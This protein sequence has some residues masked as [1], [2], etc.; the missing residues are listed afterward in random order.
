MDS[1]DLDRLL[2]FLWAEDRHNFKE[3]LTRVKLHLYL[4]FLAFTVAQTGCVIESD[5][6]RHSNEAIL[7]KVCYVVSV[8]IIYIS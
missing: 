7:Y 1:H 8:F 6:Y 4:L 5:A 3:E 2:H